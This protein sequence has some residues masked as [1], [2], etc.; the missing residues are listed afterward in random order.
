M[1]ARHPIDFHPKKGGDMNPNPI[2]KR[3]LRW[4]LAGAALLLGVQALAQTYPSRP[5]KLLIPYAAGGAVDIMGRVI[6]KEL[7][8]LN[9]QAY[10]VDNKGG[11]GGA[12]AAAEVAHA[13]PDGYEI[14]IGATGPNSIA[15]AVYGDKVGFDPIKDLIPVSLIATT[16]YVLVTNNALPVKSVAELIAHAKAEPGKLNYA[17]AG[18]GGPDHL[19]GELFKR[20]AGISA[21][22]VPYKGSGPAL[23]DLMAGQVQYEFVSPLPAMPL[24]EAGKLRLL[25]V[26]SK[27]RSKALPNV[28]AVS[29]TVPGFE[30]APWYGF[31]VPARTP[32]AIVARI[33][34][35]VRKVIARDEV[36]Q[37]LR[38]RGLDPV[39]N[40][41]QEFGAFVRADLT[42]WA[43]IVKDAGVKAD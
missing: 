43:K 34:A 11:A 13:P 5:V 16:P 26:T 32:P 24:V 3:F 10:V 39:T 37:A 1:R 40:T 8:E 15:P 12:I 20:M 33:S 42:K 31:F 18:T 17:S 28:P 35:D 30:V 2:K 38:K 4:S 41:P 27:E 9:G 14:L 19:A 36:Q 21:T 29:E 22:H 7:G 25:A 23:S 6:A